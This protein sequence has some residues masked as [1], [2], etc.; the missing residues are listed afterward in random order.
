MVWRKRK[1]VQKEVIVIKAISEAFL[2]RTILDPQTTTQ[3]SI[4]S[5]GRNWSIWT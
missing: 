3:D 5:D 1:A 4:D 2:Q